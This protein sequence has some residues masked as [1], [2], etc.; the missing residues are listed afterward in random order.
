MADIQDAELV[1][2]NS[3]QARSYHYPWSTLV[4]SCLLVL[5]QQST[6][7]IEKAV[8][9]CSSNKLSINHAADSAM[10]RHAADDVETLHQLSSVRFHETLTYAAASRINN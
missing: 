9:I 8:A 5:Y 10:A 7:Y 1:I 6:G 3:I 2:G 4:M